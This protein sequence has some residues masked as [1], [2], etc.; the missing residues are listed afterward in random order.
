MIVTVCGGAYSLISDIK[1]CPPNS[2]KVSA[3]HHAAQMLDCEYIVYFHDIVKDIC[4]HMGSTLIDV[5][6][7]NIKVHGYVG[8]SAV[9]FAL[10]ELKADLVYLAGFDLYNSMYCH[11]YNGR[12]GGGRHPRSVHL[13]IWK[14][15]LRLIDKSKLRPVSGPLVGLCKP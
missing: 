8:T 9:L 4:A 15:F 7:Y 1:K 11:E 13:N 6:H 5:K 3:N 14:D 2:V 12:L 10:E